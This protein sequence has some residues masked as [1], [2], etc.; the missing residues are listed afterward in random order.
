MLLIFVASTAIDWFVLGALT[1]KV[2][3]ST[4]PCLKWQK[5]PEL[6]LPGPRPSSRYKNAKLF[7]GSGGSSDIIPS[8][9][10]VET[11]WNWRLRPSILLLNV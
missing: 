8:V 5:Y 3:W 2:P 7:P 1:L 11:I 6:E 4:I 10:S 9:T